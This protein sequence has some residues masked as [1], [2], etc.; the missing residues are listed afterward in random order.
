MAKTADTFNEDRVYTVDG[1]KGWVKALENPA[2]TPPLG[3]NPA[4]AP[5]LYAALKTV[6]TCGLRK[7]TVRDLEHWRELLTDAEGI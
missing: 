3:P 7:I 1:L 2:I 6:T 5:A 4:Y